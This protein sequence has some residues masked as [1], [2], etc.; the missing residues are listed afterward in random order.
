MEY[1]RIQNMK[2]LIIMSIILTLMGL[3]SF[4]QFIMQEAH[5]TVQWALRTNDLQ[6]KGQLLTARILSRMRALNHFAW[7]NPYAAIS[8]QSWINHSDRNSDPQKRIK[9]PAQRAI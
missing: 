9:D 5:Q 3:V 6:N 4:S 7:I 8:Y 1:Q 2:L